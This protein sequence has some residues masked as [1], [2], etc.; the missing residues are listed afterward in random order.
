MANNQWPMANG[1]WQTRIAW[2]GTGGE[3]RLRAKSRQ[4]VCENIFF[5]SLPNEVPTLP[6]AS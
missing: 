4:G 3:L 6:N 1:K 5:P 2:M